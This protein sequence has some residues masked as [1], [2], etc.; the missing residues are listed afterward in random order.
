MV[1]AACVYTCGLI[2]ACR[3]GAWGVETLLL[4]LAWKWVLPHNV[5]LLRGNHETNTITRIYGF[6]AEL[7]AKYGA[8]SKV[9]GRAAA[10]A[11]Y[12]SQ[13]S[14]LVFRERIQRRAAG[15]AGT[16]AAAL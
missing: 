1:N 15:S 8:A 11:C 3:R 5:F 6:Y 14:T 16:S 10:A 7:K 4:L 13:V 2:V 9:C 12:K